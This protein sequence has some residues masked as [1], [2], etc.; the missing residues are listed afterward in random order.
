ML[1]RN[2]LGSLASLTLAAGAAAQINFVETFNPF[3][4]AF[5]GNYGLYTG[6]SMCG[7]SGNAMLRQLS[8]AQP[9]GTLG[10]FAGV[11]LGVPCT[12]TFDY[13]LATVAS[14]NTAAAPTPWGTL[15]VQTSPTGVAPWTTIGTIT[16]QAQTGTCIT[17]TFNFTPAAGPLFIQFATTW[18]AGTNWVN[19]DNISIQQTTPCAGPIT[20][21]NTLGPAEG[22]PGANFTL[23]FQNVI[24]GAGLSYQWYES[25]VSGTGPWTAIPGATSKAIAKTQ[26]VSTWYYC[27]V[28]CSNGPVTGNSTPLFVPQSVPTFPQD[29]SGGVINPNCWAVQTVNSTALPTYDGSSAYGVGTGSARFQFYNWAATVQARLVSPI[30]TA[31]PAGA[32]VV[33]DVAGAAYTGGE[34]DQITVEQSADGGTTWTSVATL[35]NSVTGQLNPLGIAQAAG[36]VPGAGEWETV[37]LP[38]AAGTNRVRFTGISDFGNNV[39]LDNIGIYPT[40]PAYHAVVGV[41]CYDFNTSSFAESFATSVAAKAAL[42]GNSITFVNAGTTYIGIWNTGGGA[43]F[44]APTGGATTL[45]FADT[46]DGE[47]SYTP[48]L[49]TPIPG[50]STVDWTISV[51][52]IVTA[53]S[54]ANNLA[55]FSPS[56]ADVG[57]A[58]GLGFYSWNDY[59]LGEA[60]SGQVKVEEVGTTLYITWDG[61]EAYPGAPTVNPSTFQFQIDMLTGNVTIVWTSLE[62]AATTQ[63]VA[64][65]TLAGAGPT[66]PSRTLSSAT[67]TPFTLGGDIQPMSLSAV[68]RPV[69]NGPAPTYTISNIPEYFPGAGFSGLAVVFGFT[70]I[71][72]GVD[73][74]PGP[75]DIGAGG[76]SG[77]TTPDV[78]VIIG[79]VPAGP[80]TFPI[81]WSIPS[82]PGQLW[83]QAVS[84]FVPGTLVN[85]QNVGGK[86]TSNALEIYIENY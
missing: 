73:L 81:P 11:S 36:Y 25:T 48:S 82:A 44:V 22:C 71:P 54:T 56:L 68:G 20:P 43:G 84:E 29:F 47:V 13:K 64:G 19:I 9:T 30:V 3:V 12:F 39:Y 53:G 26:T 58:T 46:D 41:G 15:L 51:N 2:L 79:V 85:G 5:T 8:S 18:S 33:F 1:A 10:A 45:V 70:Q 35:D 16:N 38:I 28:T 17:R 60:G 77:Y 78:I 37:T 7:G 23:S 72:G 63:S 40:P 75:F 62:N 66:P 50:G 83:M 4:N 67:P 76:C 49:V 80:V 65:M 61:V 27:E 34:I 6:T 42:D 14:G 59:N 57:T 21:G 55:D 86:V 31:M 74:G 24:A 52:G 69:N 32:V